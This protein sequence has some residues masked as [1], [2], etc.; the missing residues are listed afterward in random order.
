[1]S[2]SGRLQF[3]RWTDRDGDEREQWA[4]VADALVSA[5]TVRPRGGRRKG[6]G[7]GRDRDDVRSRGEGAGWPGVTEP[8]PPASASSA[9]ADD[10]DDDIPF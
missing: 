5:R 3:S 1:M 10:F 7:N 9:P 8:H 6:D 4:I 2:V